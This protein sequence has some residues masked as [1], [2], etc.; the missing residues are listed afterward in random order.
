MSPVFIANPTRIGP[1]FD[2]SSMPAIA[3]NNTQIRTLINIFPPNSSTLPP[4]HPSNPMDLRKHHPSTMA[5]HA[6]YQ[7]YF[8]HLFA[9]QNQQ[10]IH[11]L[12]DRG[13][14]R[15]ALSEGRFWLKFILLFNWCYLKNLLL[16]INERNPIRHR[17]VSIL[18]N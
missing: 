15:S 7:F 14:K 18:Q 9:L 11:P 17:N 3:L 8:P 4:A 12:V 1:Q 16:F 2:S 5:T 13:I 6:L 10:T